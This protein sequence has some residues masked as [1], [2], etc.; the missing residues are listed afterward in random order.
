MLAFAFAVGSG[1]V[2]H[3]RPAGVDLTWLWVVLLIVVGRYLLAKARGLGRILRSPALESTTVA[4]V[5]A[6]FALLLGLGD[7]V[8]GYHSKPLSYA[9]FALAA[10]AFVWFVVVTIRAHRGTAASTPM[11]PPG[12][13]LHR[14]ESTGDSRGRVT[15][16][17]ETTGHLDVDVTPDTL[18]TK[19]TFPEPTVETRQSPGAEAG[20]SPDGSLYVRAIGTTEPTGVTGFFPGVEDPV[21]L[22][23]APL[24][25]RMADEIKR[26]PGKVTRTFRGE[27]AWKLTADPEHYDKLDHLLALLH[28]GSAVVKTARGDPYHLPNLDA[29]AAWTSKCDSYLEGIYGPIKVA[30][31]Q[32]AEYSPKNP[33]EA[34]AISK[35]Q[36]RLD[37]I[38]E[39]LE[40]EGG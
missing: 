14:E 26:E 15:R 32:T 27:A 3:A 5:F 21:I 12:D 29:C 9:F 10:I 16:R 39:R 25:D 40:A 31:M 30:L 37:W 7:S 2:H 20:Y 34:A 36:K 13:H 23:A 24:I 19:T 8:G 1:V 38:R 35:A 22:H 6:V 28:E 11:V 4:L 17:E 18:E 33:H